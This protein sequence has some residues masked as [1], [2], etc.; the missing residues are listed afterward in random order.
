MVR[1]TVGAVPVFF[2]V[3]EPVKSVV[4][5][6][7]TKGAPGPVGL[8]VDMLAADAAYAGAVTATATTGTVHRLARITWRRSG[9]IPVT[10]GS[11]SIVG[12]L[13]I[14]RLMSGAA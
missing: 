9:L 6:T 11:P 3:R 8:L 14:P 2:S 13:R 10:S 12:E 5:V 7:V 4:G 1:E